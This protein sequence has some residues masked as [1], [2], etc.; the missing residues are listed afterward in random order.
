MLIIPYTWQPL[1]R[2]NDVR[3][4]GIT[5]MLLSLTT[6]G[7]DPGLMLNPADV[8]WRLKYCVLASN[9]SL[10][11]VVEDNRSNTVTCNTANK[12]AVSVALTEACSGVQKQMVWSRLMVHY[13]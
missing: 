11:A 8:M 12:V 6:I 5:L 13:V 7:C 2:S 10:K 9:L 3:H 1:Q 4:T